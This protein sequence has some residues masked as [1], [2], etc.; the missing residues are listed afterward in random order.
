MERTNATEGTPLFSGD[1]TLEALLADDQADQP[2]QLGD[3]ALF[4]G[5][6]F[7]GSSPDGVF[8]SED[9]DSDPLSGLEGDLDDLAKGIQTD[10]SDAASDAAPA[11]AP[12]LPMDLAPAPP[13]TQPIPMP[14]SVAQIAPQPK[15]R[16]CDEYDDGAASLWES[17]PAPP[18]GLVPVPPPNQPHPQAEPAAQAA[19]AAQA[20]PQS[21]KRKC[22][23]GEGGATKKR[24]TAADW[25]AIGDLPISIA[26]LWR[27]AQGKTK[28]KT[29]TNQEVYIAAKSF[30]EADRLLKES[31]LEDA[32]RKRMKAHFQY[33]AK[34][35]IITGPG[36][37]E[38]L[39]ITGNTVKPAA[40]K[41][42]T[43]G[44]IANMRKGK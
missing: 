32:E 25:E 8:G 3:G 27:L 28:S 26:P 42:G 13:S 34:Q 43:D 44:Y 11:A 21:K 5:S 29:Q 7:D 35:G 30:N 22:E 33:Y 40:K 1:P 6:L 9:A 18:M 41:A 38:Y 4:L 39:R 17:A 37:D 36:A 20:A 24:M 31:S 10:T 23:E 15:K 19:Q 2:Y 16:K 14:E 12:A